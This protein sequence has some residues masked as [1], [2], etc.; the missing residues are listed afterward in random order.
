VQTLSPLQLVIV[1]LVSAVAGAI[2]AVAG[3]GMLL[4][5]PALIGLGIPPI[6]ANATSTVA[7]WPGSG[8]SVLGYRDEL[9]GARR[10]A[11]VFAIPCVLGG[12]VGAVLLVRTPAARFSRLVPWLV[13]SAT[14][15]FIVQGP[16]SAL[17]RRKA[18]TAPNGTG[19][20]T[21]PP[22]AG[23]LA[24]QFLIAIY[25]GYFGAGAGIVMLA[26]FGLMGLTNI[27]RMNGLKNFGGVCMNA[28]AA[29]TF[30]ATGLVNWPV[31]LTMAAGALGGGYVGSRTAQRVGQGAVRMA[32]VVIGI[33]SGVWLLV[34]G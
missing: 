11:I 24:F 23:F 25:G 34:T 22:P 31:A 1:V 2:N 6:I 13:L 20:T 15:L 33:G 30:A 5:F 28:A 19:A 8:G 29:I 7:L 17:I 10:W 14:A 3:G 26:A 21:R 9:R 18:A 32:I 27:H 12:L 16:M 4:V